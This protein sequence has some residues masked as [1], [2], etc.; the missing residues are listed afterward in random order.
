M[1]GRTDSRL[2]LVVLLVVIVTVASLLGMRLAYWQI[3]QADMLRRIAA[4]QLLSPEDEERIERGQITDRHGSVLATTAYRDLLAAYPDLM[5]EEERDATA[6][7]VAQI[8]ELDA[9]AATDLRAKFT[10]ERPYLIL[11][12]RLTSQQSDAVRAGL[13]SGDLV[14]LGLE[15][16]P[17]RFYP[18]A[19]GSPDTSLAS[20]L[21]GF[22][23]EDG[24][25]RYGVE[26]A[27]HD[28]LGADPGAVASTGGAAPAPGEGG[29]IELTIDASLQLRLEKELYAA[30]V[31]DRA[32]RVTG[33]I[34]D[35]YT[36]AILAWASVPGYDANEYGAAADSAPSLFGDPVY[37]QVYEPGSVMKM[38]TA[39]TALE[40][41]VVTLTTPVQDDR[42][43]ILGS[44]I[45]ENFDRK[46][47]GV[48][49]FEDAIAHSRNVA[50]GKVALSL[51]DTVAEASTHLYDM[52]RRMGVG[53][54]TGIELPGESA[55]I[56]DDPA[57]IQ[58]QAIDLVN[59]SFGQAVA[60]TPLQ[61]VRA[62]ASMIN[63]GTLPQ[64]HV[65]AAIDG[66]PI[67]V[68][69]GPQ[70]I[71]PELSATL[72]QLMVHVIDEGPHY[73]AETLIPGYV[74]GGKTG[75]AQIWDSN[76]GMW[77]N[78]VY[79]HTFIGFV[80]AEQPA[81]VILVRIHDTEPRVHKR[82]GW[83]L[84]LTS[85]ELFRRVALDTIDAL[86]IP[87]LAGTDPTDGTPDSTDLPE[88]TTTPQPVPVAAGG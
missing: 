76:A 88:Q 33:V 39:A 77:L 46:G 74:V 18:S 84:E 37:S 53:S 51:A 87:P 13:T 30:W 54:Y 3:T 80:G 60:L 6:A 26:Q 1:L 85:N 71:S 8:L 75:T 38:F 81:A 16:H 23:T 24:Q 70:V 40:Q 7:G 83:T 62:F 47:L 17:V 32:K 59:R 27:G 69:S 50:T 4:A 20:Q 86:D 2:R 43:L 72:R 65:Y 29:S 78:R 35:P 19:G 56:V 10:A 12:R 82:W 31:A 34:M 63:G 57:D 41:G 22:V 68:A 48:I 73:A 21:L 15:P 58:W 42:Q 61:L 25:G 52:W 55:G 66:A 67:D 45:I 36:G 28:I 64:P 79:N 49:A 5:S 14:Q 9:E 44:S 11:D